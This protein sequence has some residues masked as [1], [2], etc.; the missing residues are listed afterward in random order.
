MSDILAP[1]N[2][3][4]RAAVTAPEAP[5]MV[6]AGPGSGKT[7]VLAH[8]I[9]YLI[10]E[11]G[12]PPF[13]ILAVTFTNKA[14]KEMR[15]RV[16][17]LVG[18]EQGK[19]VSLGTFHAIC[20]QI[21]RREAEHTP[22]YTGNFV[23][24]DTNDQRKLIKDIILAE[25]LD[26]KKY[27]PNAILGAISAA[28]NEMISPEKMMTGYYDME[29]VRRVYAKYNKQLRVSNARDFDDLLTHVA[30]LFRRYS[31]V[32]EK[33]W[34]FFAHVM[35]DEFQDTNMVQY[36]IIKQLATENRNVF[37]V[38]DPDQSIYGFRGA[39]YRNIRRFQED[40]EPDVILLREN[41]RSHQFI[42][43]GAMGLIRNNTDHIK[44]DLNSSR[45]EGAKIVLHES[46]NEQD[47]AHYVLDVIETT[48]S[49]GDYELSDFAVLYRTNAQSRPLE[50]LF[51]RAGLPHV[52]IGATR[53][54]ARREIKDVLAYLR[55]LHN[56][57]DIV[58]FDR[59]LN[60][61]PR[62]IG[63]KTAQQFYA[64][65]ETLS[66]G[67]WE[68]LQILVD[69]E[70]T[71][72]SGRS[73]GALTDFA[74]LIV[75]LRDE[76]DNS[77]PFELMDEILTN[78]RYIEYLER[79]E[80]TKAQERTENVEELRRVAHEKRDMTLGEFLNDVALVSE[81]D[82]MTDSSQAVRLMTLHAAKGLEFP[83]VFMV[84]ME[85]GILPHKRS[86]GDNAAIAEERRLAYVGITRAEDHL[87]MTYTFRRSMYG[88]QDPAMPSRF[89]REI[90]PDV[91]SG[92]QQT[93][94]K[95]KKSKPRPGQVYYVE[96][97]ETEWQPVRRDEKPARPKKKTKPAT[98][99]KAG[100][101]VRHPSFGEG[102]VIKSTSSS[103]VE[104]VEVLFQKDSTKSKKLDAAFLE[105]VE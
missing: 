86:L 43:D 73:K 51:V 54:Y 103:G 14:A 69:G 81:I 55:V 48:A 18:E 21:L 72:L 104:I 34:R 31:M 87:H 64:W 37:V 30:V 75:R 74:A 88:T 78:T 4:Q 38:G 95:K 83:F 60:T 13:R 80:R 45:K 63:K 89:L 71:P 53:F 66:G 9:A 97:F 33:Y 6:V 15:L 16:D 76:I 1:L 40:F 32:L 20:N 105:A 90:P 70:S 47:E 8:R 5:V 27:S 19:E 25:K 11:L 28:K 26:P 58:S 46:H 3:E 41:Y 99:F 92:Y 67:T 59:I 79:E 24:F 42:L 57:L 12:V 44:R 23:I 10:D 101:K 91:T 68:A 7:R 84:G 39:D 49:K 82:N 98:T 52:I 17:R 35:V 22:P 93:E 29:V 62:G 77:T 56:P 61:P 94:K 100:Q 102:V 2:A 65:A 36:D 50:E 85:E 96:K